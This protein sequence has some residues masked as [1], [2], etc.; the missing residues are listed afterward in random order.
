[1]RI[2]VDKVM[3]DC[4]NEKYNLKLSYKDFKDFYIEVVKVARLEKVLL[5]EYK[6]LQDEI[7]MQKIEK[8]I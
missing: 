3:I 8:N 1:M 7:I 4:M 2:V 5:R 6:A